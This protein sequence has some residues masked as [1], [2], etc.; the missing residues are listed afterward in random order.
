MEMT[1]YVAEIHSPL[2]Y[3]ASEGTLIRTGEILSSTALSYA[4]GYSLGLLKK[5]YFL[6]GKEAYQHQYEELASTGLFVTDGVPLHLT[7]TEEVFKSTEYLSERS[8]TVNVSSNRKGDLGRFTKTDPK[9]MGSDAPAAINKVRR[10]IGLAPGSEFSFTVW[11]LE[12]LPDDLLLTMGI[13]RSGEVRLKK[14]TNPRTVCLNLFMLH[15]VYGIPSARGAGEGAVSL[16]DIY[17]HASTLVR[18]SDY[19]DHHFLDVDVKFVEDVLV[20]EIMAT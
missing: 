4:L 7:Y 11:S 12:P 19:R 2:F 8:L 1:T 20:P 15:D 13:R 5:R 10:Y 3:A 16:I 14:T 9:R 6:Y 17:N 18:G